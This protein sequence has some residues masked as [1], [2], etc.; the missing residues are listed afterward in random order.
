MACPTSQVGDGTTSVVVLAGELLRE[1]EQLVAQKVHP[2]VIIA[3]TRRRAG[4]VQSAGGRPGRP[5]MGA[6]R[7]ASA[8]QVRPTCSAAAAAAAAAVA[9]A[10][11][12]HPAHAR[13][14]P[15]PLPGFRE[16]AEAARQRLLAV[17]RD[18]KADA[19]AFRRD[20]LNIAKTTLSSKIL[21]QGGRAGG[22][23]GGGDAHGQRL[24]GSRRKGAWQAATARRE[25]ALACC[26]DG[27]Q[28]RPLP[29]MHRTRVTTCTPPPP[30]PALCREGALC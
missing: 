13:H 14:H 20:L 8:R 23:A 17:A 4:Q 27:G 1:A 22:A 26:L 25:R 7:E 16:A 6:A 3:G 5:R 21:T 12:G 15:R 10:L 19:A 24:W 2:M 29:G 18:N 30:R 11:P 28:R 9:R